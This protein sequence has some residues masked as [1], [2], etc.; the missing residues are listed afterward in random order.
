MA[1]EIMTADQG[2]FIVNNTTEK[3]IDH[4]GIYVLE[5]TVFTSIKIGGSDIKGT[6][7]A[8]TAAAVKAGSFIRPVFGATFS[9]VQLT[10]GS[11]VLIL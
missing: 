2:V 6:Y 11:V 10:S 3:T 4:N 5:D 1:E 9:G 8:D 7:I